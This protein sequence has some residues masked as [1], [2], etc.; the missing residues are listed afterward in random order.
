MSERYVRGRKEMKRE[1]H[2]WK[3]HGH[4]R[5]GCNLLHGALDGSGRASWPKIEGTLHSTAA[6]YPEIGSSVA[7]W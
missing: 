2:G 3:V 7:G 6:A 1:I 5:Q 4:R